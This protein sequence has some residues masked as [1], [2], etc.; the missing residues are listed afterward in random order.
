V[1][2]LNP[3]DR[4]A[5]PLL[6]EVRWQWLWRGHVLRPRIAVVELPERGVNREVGRG[7]VV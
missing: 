7:D 4:D 5:A 2:G 1:H 6:D 3:R